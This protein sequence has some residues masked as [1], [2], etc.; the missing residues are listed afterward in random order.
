M[1]F[2]L[3]DEQQAILDGLEG[4]LQQPVEGATDP[5]SPPYSEALEQRLADA[6][7]LSIAREDGFGTL[8]AGLIVERIARAPQVVEAAATAL[9]APAL[10]LPAELRPLALVSDSWQK[11][12]RFL[13]QAQVLLVDQG[14]R[15]LALAVDPERVVPGDTLFAYPYGRLQ[16]SAQPTV[17]AEIDPQVL[18]RRWRMALAVEAAGCMAAALALV[19]EHVRTRQAFGRPLGAFQAIQHRLAMAAE[20]VE[21][22]KWLALRACWSDNELDASLAATFAQ[23]RSNALTYDLHQ[24]SGAMGLTLEYPLHRWTYRLRALVGELGGASQQARAAAE[25]AW[26]ETCA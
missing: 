23:S 15:A 3:S 9:I 14:D 6:G 13:P 20:T 5:L 21:S 16:G 19:L 22:C 11:P 8:D 17:L 26:P 4:L 12:A 7:Y 24:F 25:A 2:A 10:G 18:R 1:N